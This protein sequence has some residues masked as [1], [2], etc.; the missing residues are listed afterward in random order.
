MK[1]KNRKKVWVKV[2]TIVEV[3]QMVLA[4]TSKP[5]E[6]EEKRLFRKL[7]RAIRVIEDR[8]HSHF[9][10]EAQVRYTNDIIDCSL[11]SNGRPMWT[12]FKKE[13]GEVKK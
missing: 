1:T 3:S 11:E 7:E 13:K 10:E 8:T 6:K 5:F 4:D 9:K 12:A 2:S